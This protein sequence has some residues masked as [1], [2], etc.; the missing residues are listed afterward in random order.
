MYCCYKLI[1]LEIV[2]QK[3]KKQMSLKKKPSKQNFTAYFVFISL[4]KLRCFFNDFILNLIASL[5]TISGRNWFF[6]KVSSQ[7]KNKILNYLNVTCIEYKLWIFIFIQVNILLFA[8]TGMTKQNFTLVEVLSV[9]PFP[10]KN[11]TYWCLPLKKWQNFT[12]FMFM[13]NI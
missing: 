9:V 1:F 6:L 10:S 13:E 4:I 12:L 11:K 2:L 8:A 3:Y 5:E 7:D